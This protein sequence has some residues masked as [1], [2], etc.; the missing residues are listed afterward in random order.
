MGMSYLP[1]YNLFFVYKGKVTCGAIMCANWLTASLH[2]INKMVHILTVQ[3]INAALKVD[4]DL[5][6]L[7]QFTIDNVY[8]EAIRVKKTISLPTLFVGIFLK[9]NLTPVQV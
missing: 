1:W 3:A 5:D 4:P 2:Q 8:M 7:G 9:G 6:L